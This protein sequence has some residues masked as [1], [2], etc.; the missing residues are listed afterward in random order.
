MS[1]KTFL[2][3]SSALLIISTLILTLTSASELSERKPVA[4]TRAE[5]IILTPARDKIAN[6]PQVPSKQRISLDYDGEYLTFGFVVPEGECDVVLTE[7]YSGAVQTYTIDSTP[8]S[9]E[10]YVGELYEST[11]TITTAKDNT[12]TAE[13]T[14]EEE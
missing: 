10:I 14:A 1:K 12:Y 2:K 4:S 8:L 3:T 7:W 9:A 13:L 5:R 11:V 6:R